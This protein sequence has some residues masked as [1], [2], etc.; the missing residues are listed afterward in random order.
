MDN[1]TLL[2]ATAIIWGAFT[3]ITSIFLVK[4]MEAIN[5][6]NSTLSREF[7]IIGGVIGILATGAFLTTAS[8][9][10]IASQMR[11]QNDELPAKQKRDKKRLENLLQLMDEDEK[12]ELE[13][14][15]RARELDRLR[16]DA[17]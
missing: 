2:K 7:L 17:F 12:Q 5:Y 3:I 16:S 4:S 9:W 8:I 13:N 10:G 1:E 6:T 15:I 11:E 14:M